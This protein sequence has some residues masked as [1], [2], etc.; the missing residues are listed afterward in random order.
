MGIVG[1]W[2]KFFNA[3]MVTP[4][5]V[6]G[7]LTSKDNFDMDMRADAWYITWRKVGESGWYVACFRNVDKYDSILTITSH[8]HRK[9]KEELRRV[10]QEVTHQIV[11]NFS[12]FLLLSGC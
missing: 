5:V 3:T 7:G 11:G 9:S 12:S 1:A 4:D 2:P 8:K 10:I 6:C